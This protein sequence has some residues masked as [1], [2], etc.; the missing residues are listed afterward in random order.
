MTSWLY[1]HTRGAQ[2]LSY[3]F[4]SYFNGALKCNCNSSGTVNPS[5]C[6]LYGGQCEYLNIWC[7][8]V[9]LKV[10]YWHSGQTAAVFKQFT[11]CSNKAPAMHHSS[12]NF[13]HAR[14]KVTGPNKQKTYLHLWLLKST[15]FRRQ[16]QD[17]RVQTNMWSLSSW[18]LRYQIRV[19]MSPVWLLWKRIAQ[20]VLS[21][22]DRTVPL[23]NGRGRTRL[24]AVQ[25][26]LLWYR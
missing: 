24:R 25:S 17:K 11:A 13:G 6:N 4:G 1:E 12:L 2:Y 22:F 9:D 26:G 14:L 18:T 15:H 21:S 5:V 7:M 3:V 19:R 20:S 10:F 16:M 8:H 23:Q